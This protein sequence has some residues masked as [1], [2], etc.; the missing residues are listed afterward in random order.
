MEKNA[1]KR[2]IIKNCLWDLGLHEKDFFITLPFSFAL[3]YV[4]SSAP[5]HNINLPSLSP[6]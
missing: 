5:K 4:F 3:L 1:M 2:L 6:E